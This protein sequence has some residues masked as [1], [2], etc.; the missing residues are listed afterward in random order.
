VW[1]PFFFFTLDVNVMIWCFIW[2]LMGRSENNSKKR[3]YFSRTLH[4]LLILT[5][6]VPVKLLHNIKCTPL[7]CAKINSYLSS[8]VLNRVCNSFFLSRCFFPQ[9]NENINTLEKK[10]I[11]FFLYSGAN[12][13]S[14]QSKAKTVNYHHQF[15]ETIGGFSTIYY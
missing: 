5:K 1:L 15:F 3:I 7:P 13:D 8:G 2:G 11:L 12:E 14:V 4:L 6:F 10:I 9:Y